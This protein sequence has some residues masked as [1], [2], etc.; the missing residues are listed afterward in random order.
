MAKRRATAAAT[1][2]PAPAGWVWNPWVD[3]IIGCGGWTLPLVALT[4]LLSRSAGLDVAFGF[5]L[6]TLVCN[7][8]HYMA[9][10]VRAVSGEV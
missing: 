7:H 10:V 2:T 1:A 4:Y 8:P 5:S 3:L 9:T 6:L